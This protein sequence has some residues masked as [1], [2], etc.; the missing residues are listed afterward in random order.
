MSPD[1]RAHVVFP[2]QDVLCDP[3]FARLDF[4]SCRNLLIYL[5]PEA[6]SRAF[7]IFHF[8]L[9][10]GGLLLIGAAE[11]V[12]RATAGLSGLQARA[13]VSAGSAQVRPSELAVMPNPGDGLRARTT[14]PAV[15]APRGRR[16]LRRTVRP[17][18]RGDVWAG[19]GAGQ[20]QVRVPALAR[21]D[22]SLSQG[23]IGTT[24]VRHRRP[25]ARGRA[26][27]IAGRPARRRN[28]AANASSSRAGGSKDANDVRM[29]SVAVD[30]AVQRGRTAAARLLPRTPPPERVDPGVAPSDALPRVAEL[31]RELEATKSDLQKALRNLEASSE[32]QMA[33]NEEALS[34]NEE[35]Q[36]TNEEL[37]DLEGGVAV[38]ER[39]IERAQQSV[40]GDARSASAPPRTISRTCSTAP[41]RRRSFSTPT[42]TF[43]S[44]PRRPNP[45]FNVI[46]GDIGRPLA[47]LKSLAIDGDLLPDA[48]NVLRDHATIEREIEE[49]GGGVVHPPHPALSHAR[50]AVERRRRHV[51]GHH[52]ADAERR[53]R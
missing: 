52:R 45:L 24:D 48:R 34:V 46:P 42:S 53:K 1:L 49:S 11:A 5:N 41:I 23:R 30:A 14:E 8:A 36:S 22:G 40:A 32:E 19:G 31:E 3:P 2:V 18:G 9:R 13:T 38:A 51:R 6:Q 15:R 39:G 12:A 50:Q 25:G 35:Y 10:P 27:Q 43:A 21:A 37:L 47:D 20:R 16:Q 29:F 28:S 33:I 44:S 26:N 4:I 7:A 17:T